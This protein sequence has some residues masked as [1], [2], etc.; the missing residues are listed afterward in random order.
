M[1]Q[2]LANQQGSFIVANSW[3][4]LEFSNNTG[5]LLSYATCIHMATSAHATFRVQNLQSNLS[6]AMNV[7]LARYVPMDLHNNI[8]EVRTWNVVCLLLK[9]KLP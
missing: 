1:L 9:R 3:L 5:L 6:T 4:R 7:E 8:T 2:L